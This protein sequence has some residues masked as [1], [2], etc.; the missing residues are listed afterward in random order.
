MS[1]R[2]KKHR[3]EIP[4]ALRIPAAEQLLIDELPAIR[5]TRIL[6][7]SLGRGQFAAAAARQIPGARVTLHELDIYLADEA[8]RFLEQTASV[9]GGAGEGAA[10]VVCS[11][12]FPEEQFDLAALPVDFRG[13]AE[14]T[15]DRLQ[16]AHTRLAI[17]GR[18]LSATGNPEDQWLHDELRKMF[19]KVTRR[20]SE[21]GVLYLATKVAPL[22]KLK[23]YDAEFAFRD[24][25]QL[26]RAIS[27]PGVFNH[28]G[29][30]AG[31]RA[32][33]NTMQIAEGA[34]VLDLGCG[35]G[36]VAFA[37]ALRANGVTVVAV[38]S[39]ARAIDCTLRGAALNG[40][41]NVRTILNAEGETGEPGTFDL[42]V[43]NPP[44]YS[45]YRI[46]EI[47]LQ[48]A[49]KALRPGGTL[50]IVT[51]AVTWYEERLPELFDQ[52]RR[53]IHKAYSVLEARQRRPS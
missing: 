52:V 51:K 44:Y 38:D 23:H 37:A 2:D 49:R 48:G 17:G 41:T 31:A 35:S 7:T 21:T 45:D 46:A 5:E 10:R 26:I 39:H 47:F 32:L 20:P 14:L 12:D 16:A 9:A 34:R 43:G 50:L 40:L 24:R 30:D 28:R 4:P 29:L 11:A 22:K 42:V 3:H 36:V 15:R 27:R 6:A 33:V 13:D 19:A 1:R 8:R 18:L 25:G 53:N